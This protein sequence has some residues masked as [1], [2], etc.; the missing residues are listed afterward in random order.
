MNAKVT[1]WGAVAF[2][3]AVT[4]N[5]DTLY[6]QVGNGTMGDFTYATLYATETPGGNGT[7]VDTVFADGVTG[8]NYTTTTGTQVSPV[9]SDLGSYGSS[10]YYFYVETTNY[11]NNQWTTD[12]QNKNYPWSYTELVNSGYISTGSGVAAPTAIATGGAL[13]GGSVPEPTSG[14][15]LLIGGSLLAL[16][17]RRR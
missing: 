7:A 2:V 5:A 17:R 11:A 4:L 10:A 16:R 9:I 8:D 3:A 6:W 1:F 15:L 13:N 12:S 14:I